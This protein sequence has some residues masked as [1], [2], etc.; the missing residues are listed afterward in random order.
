M[1]SASSCSGCEVK[2][3][4]GVLAPHSSPMNSIG[5]NGEVSRIS[6]PTRARPVV[7][8]WLSRSPVARLPIW[9]WFCRHTTKRYPGTADRSTGL[10]C[11]CPRNSENVPSW[12]NAD[13]STLA[14]PAIVPKS[15]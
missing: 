14:R 8:I 11:G 9:S 13:V 12:K 4:H 6:A 3:C 2:N 5:V 15:T 7:A 1:A 10:P